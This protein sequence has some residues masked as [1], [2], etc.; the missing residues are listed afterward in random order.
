MPPVIE[1]G[2]AKN[3]ANFEDSVLAE[4]PAS[5]TPMFAIH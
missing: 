5:G 2:H 1:T 3:V 4:S